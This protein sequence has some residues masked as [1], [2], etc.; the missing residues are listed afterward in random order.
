MVMPC[1]SSSTG[2]YSPGRFSS[3]RWYVQRQDWAQAPLL[4]LR[5]A[6]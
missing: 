3:I 2:K 1:S 4:A 5:E 6:R